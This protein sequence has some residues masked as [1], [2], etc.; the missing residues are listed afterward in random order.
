[1]AEI[2]GKDGYRSATVTAICAEAGLSRQTF[3]QHFD[4]REACFVAV[5]DE[6][7]ALG[8]GVIV[9]A[10]RSSATW[11]QGLRQALATLLSLFDS[12]P[13]FARMWMIESIAAGPPVLMHREKLLMKLTEE[14]VGC[15]E[16]FPVAPRRSGST[17]SSAIMAAVVAAIQRHLLTDA[18]GPLLDLLGS[19]MGIA[20]SPFLDRDEV[21]GE[22]RR[23]EE[24]A[25]EISEQ[26]PHPIRLRDLDAPT[27]PT[28]LLDARAHRARAVLCYLTSHPGASNRELAKGVGISSDTQMSVLLNRLVE[29]EMIHKQAGAPG[30]PNSCTLTPTGEVAATALMGM[31]EGDATQLP[32]TLAAKVKS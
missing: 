5:L 18:D 31:L 3:Y 17:V 29:M 23:G 12:H 26:A 13:A 2:V 22:I 7:Y 21:A 19:L 28:R 25:R 16:G 6:A 10:I 1:M 8:A 4:D 11:Q 15:W 24:A 30:H 14:I 27:I 9:R 32:D 20:T